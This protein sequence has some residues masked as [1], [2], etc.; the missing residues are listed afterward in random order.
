MLRKIYTHEIFTLDAEICIDFLRQ[1]MEKNEVKSYTYLY[2]SS[3]LPFTDCM[4]RTLS[5]SAPFQVDKQKKPDLDHKKAKKINTERKEN[6]FFSRFSKS[7]IPFIT[8]ISK[9][10]NPLFCGAPATF[11]QCEQTVYEEDDCWK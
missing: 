5:F 7:C 10:L 8:K 4:H 3:Y 2:L 1:L 6:T 11:A 9:R